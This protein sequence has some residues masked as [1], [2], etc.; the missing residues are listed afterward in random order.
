MHVEGRAVPNDLIRWTNGR[1]R[2]VT[3]T[4]LRPVRHNGRP[5]GIAP[6]PLRCSAPCSAFA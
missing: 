1:A 6:G 2:E 4:V 3:G 5:H